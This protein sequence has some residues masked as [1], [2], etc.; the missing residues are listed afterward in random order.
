MG[1]ILY[2]CHFEI[3]PLSLILGI[4]I[5]V[6]FF[7]VGISKYDIQKKEHHTSIKHVKIICLCFVLFGIVTICILIDMYRKTVIA[8]RNDDYQI[9]EGYV[10]NFDPMPYGGHKDETFEING[11]KFGYSDYTIMIG[12]H[13]TKSHGGV[14]R[15]NGQYLKIGYIQYNNENIIVYIE[16][17]P[18][19]SYLDIEILR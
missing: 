9:V 16:E 7:I 2:E 17:F 3:E 13:N 12:Y 10:V 4:I 8:Y 5:I 15:D 1:R 18:D 14:I 19:K 11:V 6:A